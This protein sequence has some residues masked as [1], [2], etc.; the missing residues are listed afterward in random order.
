[1][2]GR[3]DDEVALRSA[4][5]AAVLEPD[6]AALARG[7]D[8]L[9]GPRGVK[10]SGGQVQRTAAARMFLGEPELLVLDDLSSA[11]DTDTEAELWRRLF[12]R[13]REATCLIVSHRPAALRRADQVLVMDD[14]RLVAGGTLDGLLTSSEGA[15]VLSEAGRY[16]VRNAC[17]VFDAW[18]PRDASTGPRYSSTV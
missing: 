6:I 3:A 10:L 14:G 18:L 2:L 5:R 12:A 9:V 15:I 1:M 13:G 16:L 4:I 17:M 8:T 11:L 7:L